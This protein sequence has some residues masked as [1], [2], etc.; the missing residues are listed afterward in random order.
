[1]IVHKSWKSG[2][3]CT[4]CKQLNRLEGVLSQWSVGLNSFQEVQLVFGSFRWLGWSLC[5][6]ENMDSF[7]IHP[8]SLAGVIFF[9]MVGLSQRLLCNL[10]PLSGVFTAYIV[11]GREWSSESYWFQELPETIELFT[12]CL[13]EL[14]FRMGCFTSLRKSGCFALP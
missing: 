13:N 3:F 11:L 4:A 7:L 12:S 10:A 2:A 8:G 14:P 9:H 5:L 1:M 6:L